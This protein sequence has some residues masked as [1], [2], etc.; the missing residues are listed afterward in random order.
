MREYIIQPGDNFYRLA[1]QNGG[2]WQEYAAC[3]PGVDPCALQVGQKIIMPIVIKKKTAGGCEGYT[4]KGRC[5]DVFVEIEGLTFRVTRQGEPSLPHEVH[6]II[7]RTEITKVEHPGTGIIETSI[8]LS[9]INIVN[10]P[11]YHGE[12]GETTRIEQS[13]PI[14]DQFNSR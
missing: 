5:D 6:L 3:N 12:G 4:G 14:T 9:N 2:S 7:P 10:S 11:R 1:E 13:E 8:M